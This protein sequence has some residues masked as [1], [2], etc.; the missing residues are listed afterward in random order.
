MEMVVVDGGDGDGDGD[1]C[2]GRVIENFSQ[3]NRL[4]LPPQLIADL[5]AV[6]RVH[7]RTSGDLMEQISNLVHRHPDKLI[8]SD[9]VCMEGRLITSWCMPI[10]LPNADDCNYCV[11]RFSGL[12]LGPFELQALQD[13]EYKFMSTYVKVGSSKK[14]GVPVAG[15]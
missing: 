11:C 9:D 1:G 12:G 3:A 10:F 4:P 14:E 7:R 5:V 2:C 6:A 15:G 13:W 8:V